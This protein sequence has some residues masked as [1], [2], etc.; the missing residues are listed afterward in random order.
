MEMEKSR[1]ANHSNVANIDGDFLHRKFLYAYSGVGVRGLS[2][3]QGRPAWRVRYQHQRKGHDVVLTYK[4][5]QEGD[6]FLVRSW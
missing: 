2:H 4:T 3:R 1:L 6:L 5:D